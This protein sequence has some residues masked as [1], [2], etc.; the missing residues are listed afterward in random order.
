MELSAALVSSDKDRAE[1]LM[2]ADLLRNDISR[3]G[4]AGTV[5]ASELFR[6]ESFATVHHLVST[7]E[8]RL[9][10]GRGPSDLLRAAFP[11]GSVTG[12]PKIRAMEIISELEPVARGPYCGALGYLGFGSDM[13]TSVSIRI[14]VAVEDRVVFHAGGAV[15][16]DSDPAAEYEETLDKTR[17]LVSAMPGAGR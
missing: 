13:D 9:R 4:R 12:A 17:A 2:I 1:N 16:V 7:V 11:S 6:L 15:V 3:I 10:E 5:R 8:G 14:A